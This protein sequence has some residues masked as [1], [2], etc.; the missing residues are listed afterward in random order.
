[1]PRAKRPNGADNVQ[2][3]LLLRKRKHDIEYLGQNIVH[4]AY[5]IDC[6]ERKL[7]LSWGNFPH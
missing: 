6:S 3:Y 4:W 1:M 7:G 2:I 5:L